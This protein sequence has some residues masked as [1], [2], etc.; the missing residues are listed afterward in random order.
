MSGRTNLVEPA[1]TDFVWRKKV[2]STNTPHW[3][4][5]SRSNMELRQ[6]INSCDNYKKLGTLLSFVR[7]ISFI[8]RKQK[9][10]LSREDY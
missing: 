3:L 8:E 5:E 7:T 4:P 6:S 2:Q 9:P 1:S 10:S